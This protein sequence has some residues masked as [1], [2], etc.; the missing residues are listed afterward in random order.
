MLYQNKNVQI[1]LKKWPI[2]VIFQY[3]LYIFGI[4]LWTVLHS[5]PCYNEPCNKE[6]V[7]Y[8]ELFLNPNLNWQ[9][10]LSNQWK[11]KNDQSLRMSVAELCDLLIISWMRIWLSHLGR[12]IWSAHIVKGTVTNTILSANADDKVIHSEFFSENRACISSKLAPCFLRK[13]LKKKKK[14]K[15][16]KC[17]L[18]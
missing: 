1:I 14:K 2:M 9:M 10:P 4:Q 12:H 8:L 6:V 15:N 3:N 7:V 5:K 17:D 11:G 16:S 13:K 18:K